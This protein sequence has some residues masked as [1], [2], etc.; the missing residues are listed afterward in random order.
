M[1]LITQGYGSKGL[2]TQGFLQPQEVFPRTLGRVTRLA[3][4]GCPGAYWEADVEFNGPYCVQRLAV[5]CPGSKV[6]SVF[7]PGG[8]EASV[9]TPGATASQVGCE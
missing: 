3:A 4:I 5:F 6:A 2:I 8:V 7:V 1:M 9:F